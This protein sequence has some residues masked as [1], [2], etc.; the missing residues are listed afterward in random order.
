VKKLTRKGRVRNIKKEEKNNKK[1][2]PGTV[3]LKKGIDK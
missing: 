2:S 1:A 3:S